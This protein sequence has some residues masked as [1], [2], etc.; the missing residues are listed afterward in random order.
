VISRLDAALQGSESTGRLSVLAL[1]S[2]VQAVDALK[3]SP[4][5]KERIQK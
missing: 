2:I 3:L 1:A 4:R 5:M